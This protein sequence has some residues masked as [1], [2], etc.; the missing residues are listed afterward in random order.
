MFASL[1]AA[2]LV[3][4]CGSEDAPG[5]GAVPEGA[6]SVLATTTIWADIAANVGCDGVA[7]VDTLMPPGT[8]PHAYEPSLRDRA[9][10]GDAD[11]IVANGLGLDAVLDDLVGHGTAVVHV[12]DHVTTLGS[13]P[14]GAD[15][16]DDEHD[17]H[18][19]DEHDPHIWFDPTRV[20]ATL[21]AIGD[22]LVDAGA[23]RAAVD[24]CVAAYTDELTTLDGDITALVDSLPQQ[25]RSLV[26]NHHSLGYFA[27]R[28]GFTVIGTV[29]PSASSLAAPSPADLEA[30]A[31]A[32]DDA[33]V[34]AIF[35]ETQH[36]STDTGALAARL[37]DVAVVTLQTDTLGAPQSA[38]ATYVDWLRTTAGQIVDA[39]S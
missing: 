6:V 20:A 28:Y 21:P 8:D 29:I 25:R 7:H 5:A 2:G 37:G 18:E 19:D 14:R 17:E 26:T 24:A 22:A 15:H 9:R 16:H 4:A 1:A 34:P 23:D 13:T 35:A 38:T 3:A 12:G 32:I 11:V 30:L 33:G 31:H 39:L 36:A 27:D 10:I